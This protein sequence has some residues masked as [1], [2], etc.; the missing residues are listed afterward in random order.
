[1]EESQFNK[2]K[3]DK[4]RVLLALET[5]ELLQHQRETMQVVNNP[6]IGEVQVA[7]Q[8]IPQNSAFQTEDLDA[9]DLD[10]DDIS[11]AKAV[12]DGKSFKL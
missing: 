9:Y 10:C 6:G 5:D 11:L 2:F 12:P 3:E 7:Q 8:I 4:L 1:M